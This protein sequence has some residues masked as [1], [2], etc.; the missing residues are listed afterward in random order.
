VSFEFERELPGGTPVAERLV[1][2]PGRVAPGRYRVTLAV[3]DQTRNVK[4]ETAAIVVTIH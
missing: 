2:E 4:S 3:T 1:L